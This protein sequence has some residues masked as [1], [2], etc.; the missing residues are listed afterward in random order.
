[1]VIPL[2]AFLALNQIVKIIRGTGHIHIYIYISTS[3]STRRCPG[4]FN[5]NIC[6]QNTHW[7]R[8]HLEKPDQ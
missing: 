2:Q 8:E 3:R 4:K 1:M 5:F 6:M 7:A